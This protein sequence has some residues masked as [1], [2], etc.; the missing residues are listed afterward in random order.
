MFPEVTRQHEVIKQGWLLVLSH[1]EFMQ[2]PRSP[3]NPRN[4]NTPKAQQRTNNSQHAWLTDSV[5]NAG[6][7]VEPTESWGTPQQ[8]RDH[9]VSPSIKHGMR[10]TITTYSHQSRW[11]EITQVPGEAVQPHTEWFSSKQGQQ[12]KK[13]AVAVGMSNQLLDL[14]LSLAKSER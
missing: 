4:L 11:G 2:D 6:T 13:K 12:A 1:K 7:S 8:T 3:E 5:N 10:D 14:R 9:G